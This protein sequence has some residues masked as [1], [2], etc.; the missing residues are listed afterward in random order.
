MHHL[1]LIHILERHR[2]TFPIFGSRSWLQKLASSATGPIDGSIMPAWTH[3][4]L[5]RGR[6]LD[7]LA[8]TVTPVTCRT[9]KKASR[10]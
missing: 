5:V 9:Q 10:A 4:S 2:E 3:P 1:P 6:R 7:P 8:A